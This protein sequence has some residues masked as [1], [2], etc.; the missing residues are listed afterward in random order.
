MSGDYNPGREKFFAVENTGSKNR[1]VPKMICAGVWR[2]WDTKE[3][4][5]TG[6]NYSNARAVIDALAKGIRS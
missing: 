2:I 5:Y 1:Y 4:R 6:G 3:E